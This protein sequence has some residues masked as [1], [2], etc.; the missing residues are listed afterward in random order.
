M[1]LCV[2]CGF[3]E[4]REFISSKR[5]GLAI[6]IVQCKAC[7]LFFVNPLPDIKELKQLYANYE[8]ISQWDDGSDFFNHQ[9]ILAITRLTPTGGRV[10]EIGCSYGK[11]LADL[12]Q[13]GFQAMGV[14]ASPPACQY[15]NRKFDIPVYEG[16]V[17]AYLENVNEK[18]TYDAIIA[19]N[20]I[21][22]LR[23]PFVVLNGLSNIL[24]P[25]GHILVIVPDV[26]LA[27]LLGRLRKLVGDPDPYK[28]DSGED[29]A[30]VTFNSPGHLYF[31][32]R[33]TIALLCE[34]VGWEVVR[35]VQA[36]YVLS[37]RQPP[38]K[39][40][41]LKPCLY[42]L[43][44]ACEELGLGSLGLSYSQMLIARKVL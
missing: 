4:S 34:R 15:I 8:I 28:I 29:T 17:E 9:V 13:K 16:F 2:C 23:D 11:I 14:E 12:H 36:P 22:H 18:G 33:Q 42:Y 31:F 26:S 1:S 27:L 7:G 35:H 20:I 38:I 21:E 44:R 37:G 41:Y 5:S 25:G 43:T 3:Q 40:D 6:N 39:K 19:L 24:N 32:S 30:E 10:L